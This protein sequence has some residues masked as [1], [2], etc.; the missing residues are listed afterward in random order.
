MSTPTFAETY[1]LVAF[2]EKPSESKGFEKIIDFL[3][4]KS[5]RYALTVNPIVYASCVKQFWTTTKVK[6]IND[7]E[8]I[9]AL[10]DKQKVI[11]IKESIRRDL[12]FDDAEGTAC[13]PNDTI[14]AELARMGAKITAWN[15]FSS[16]MASTKKIK[17]KRNQRQAADVHSPS[18]EIPI[19]KSILTPSIDPLPSGED[20]IQ[21]NE[22]MIFSTNLQ[23][24]E[25]ASKQERS[26]EDIDQ[27]AEIALVDE[28]QRR[29]HDADIFRVDELEGN[30]VNVDV[31]EKIIEKEVSTADPVTNVGEVVTAASVED[32]AAPTTA[33]TADVDDELTLGKTLITIVAAKP[34]EERIAREKDEAN[35][36]VVKEW[37]EVQA[38]IDVD[39]QLAK[40]IQAQER[41][42]I[43]IKERSKLLAKLIESKRKYFAAKRAEEIR[44]K[45]PIKTMFEP[46]VEDIIWKYQQGEVKV[47]NWKLFDSCGVYCVTTKNMVY[48]LQVKKMYP[49]INYVL[50]QL[51]S[52][53]RLHVD[54]K[55]EM[56]YDLL[57]LIRR[58]INEGIC[59]KFLLFRCDALH[60]VTIDEEFKAISC[61]CFSEDI[62]QL[63]NS[64][65]KVQFNNLIFNLLF[66]KVVSN[67][68][69]LRP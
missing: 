6:K 20:S 19:E 67:S 42:Q 5:I 34:K 17:P 59:K 65:D 62:R 36:V 12:K 22:L 56:A 43:S 41:E 46:L 58:Q 38:I 27:D 44:N 18:S 28:A 15:E 40:Q 66:D 25:D 53:V 69:M 50:H 4:A 7:Q 26:I 51:W 35:K 8:H 21:L 37:D 3:N 9:K 29:M 33:T 31:I 1:N 60:T 32:S 49:F 13:L 14:F 47:N 48:Y 68:D 10:V 54:Y 30:E 55:V 2:L 57:R 45:P 64:L 52:D 61:E 11:I 63:V 23:Q 24:Q 16:T 39:R